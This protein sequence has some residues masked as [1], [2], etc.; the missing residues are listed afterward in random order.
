MTQL[1]EENAK[2]SRPPRLSVKRKIKDF[3]VQAKQLKGDPRYVA[4]GMAI[5]VFIGVTPTIPLHT[6]LAVA[7]AFVFKCSKPAAIIGVW[8]GNPITIPFFYIGS[9]HLG[10]FLFDISTPFN[11][12]HISIHQLMGLGLEITVAMNIGGVLLGIPFGVA[13]YFI[14]LKAFKS[15]REKEENADIPEKTTTGQ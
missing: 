10:T 4:T 8:V 13:A 1:P 7:I 12:D 15:I 6:V 14:T 11:P 2:T 3:V 9:Y 5:G